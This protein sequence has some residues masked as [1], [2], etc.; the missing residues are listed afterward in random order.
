MGLAITFAEYRFICP[1]IV[2]ILVGEDS[3]LPFESNNIKCTWLGII[4]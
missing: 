1:I 4:T 3:I 2:E